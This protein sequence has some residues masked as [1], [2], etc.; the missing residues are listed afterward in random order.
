L[1]GPLALVDAARESGGAVK[2]E[3]RAG[4]RDVLETPSF[5]AKAALTAH[6]MTVISPALSLNQAIINIALGA[7]RVSTN[8]AALSKREISGFQRL[9]IGRRAITSP[10]D[11][12]D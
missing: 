1:A 7:S 9:L 3:N 8:I 2:G 4:S 5:S 12:G 11:N 6:D 10:A